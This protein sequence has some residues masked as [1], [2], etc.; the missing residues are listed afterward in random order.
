[1]RTL[2]CLLVMLATVEWQSYAGPQKVRP[3]HTTNSVIVA[4]NN[5]ASLLYQIVSDEKHLSKL[6]IIKR[7]RRELH[8][9][10]KKISD[11]AAQTAKVLEKRAKTDTQFDI[12]QV[13]LPPGEIAAR[14]LQSSALT[15]QL[16]NTKGE[17]FEFRLLLTQAQALA[18][19]QSLATVAG[20]NEPDVAQREELTKISLRFAQLYDAVIQLLKCR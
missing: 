13:Q 20:A 3:P 14:Q 8:D 10:V 2:I 18:Y 11:T 16:L 12:T 15:R 5:S 19:A 6:L 1:M 4:R 17:E 7:D 9:L